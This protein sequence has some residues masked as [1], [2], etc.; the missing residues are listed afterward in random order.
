[1]SQGTGGAFHESLLTVTNWG[2]RLQD[3]NIPVLLWHGEADQNIPVEMA[4]FAARAIPQCEATFY[5]DEGH[6]SLFKKQAEEILRALV[7]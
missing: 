1:M 3:I 5:P 2:F 7:S 6:L 4:R